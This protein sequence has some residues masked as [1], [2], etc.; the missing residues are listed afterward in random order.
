MAAFIS[1][2]GYLLIFSLALCIATGIVILLQYLLSGPKLGPYYDFLLSRRSG[3]PLAREFLLIDTDDIMEPGDAAQVLLTLIEMDAAALVI[4]TPVLGASAGRISSEDEI[5]YRF[6]EEFTL[7]GR[8]IRNL[9]DAI[10]VGSVPPAESERY[11]GELVELSLRGKDR[12]T[13]ALVRQDEAGIK[14]M[15]QAAA[16]FGRVWKAGD[17]R[18][19][20]AMDSPWY[21]GPRPDRDG[22]LRRINPVLSGG[23]GIPGSGTEHVIYAA[24]KDRFSASG[25]EYSKFAGILINRDAEGEEAVIPLDKSGAIL[26]EGPGKDSSFR[27][28]PLELFLKYEEMDHALQRLLREADGMGIYSGIEPEDS[29]V[30]L[31]EYARSLRD[32]FLETPGPEKKADWI[33][34]RSEYFAGLDAFLSGPAETNLVTG[35]EELIAAEFSA[36]ESSAAE[37]GLSPGS[38]FPEGSLGE[39]GIARLTAL[40][41]DLIRCF[42]AIR[43]S[44]RELRELRLYLKETLDSSFAVL[45]PGPHGGGADALEFGIDPVTGLPTEAPVNRDFTATEASVVLA[46]TILSGRAVN[47]G[48]TLDILFWSLLALVLCLLIIS[49]LEPPAALVTGLVLSLFSGAAFSWSFIISGYWIDPIISVS[50]SLTGT[51][52]IFSLSRAVIRRG[53]RHFLLAYGPY[54]SKPCLNQLIRTGR[55][56]TSELIQARAAIIAVRKMNLLS[57]EDRGNPQAGAAAATAFREEVTRFFKKAGGVIIGCDGDLVLGCFGSP[58]E[59]IALG[60]MRS[61]PSSAADPYARFIY[62][63]ASRASSFVA[64]V[65]AGAAVEKAETTS[66]CFGIDTG[67]CGFRY[68]PV[69]GYSAFGR[70]VVRARILSSLAPRYNVQVVVSAAVSKS[71]PDMPVRRLNVL[72]E[73]DGSEGEAFFQL[74]MK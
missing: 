51:L 42:A 64:E 27:R 59:R 71:L 13:S 40:R 62:T 68:L 45:G 50:G 14:G 43:G 36:S 65:L 61:D 10:R 56:R 17:L 24:M 35:Y 6:D 49:R 46:N 66:W 29:P 55:P 9:F 52:L 41:D 48:Q 30:F 16:G 70:P 11:V 21:S 38:G 67:E 26:I 32:E 5:R 31:F 44:Y 74:V 22:K 15:E 63:P 72:K 2:K 53:A 25:P 60:G 7:L 4:E 8:N 28:L 20:M 34:A 1:R 19:S 47:P 58:L 39:A 54:V 18:P 23:D 33:H 3:L 37:T 73:Q 12:L 57:R 69:S